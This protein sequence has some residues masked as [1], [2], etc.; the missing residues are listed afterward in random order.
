MINKKKNL[1][2]TKSS[3]KSSGWT[4]GLIEKHLGEPD[5][6]ATNPHYKSGPPV[7]LYLIS[8]VKRCEKKKSFIDYIEK[9][10]SKR[11]I[12]SEK[13]KTRAEEE[14]Q[15][16]FS[17]ISGLDIKIPKMEKGTLIKNAVS[18][19]NELWAERGKDKYAC[20]NSDADFLN[21]ISVNYL[22]HDCS[23]YEEELGEIFGKIGVD[24]GYILLKNK[25]LEKI[26]EIYP[27]LSEACNNQLI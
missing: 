14:R 24:D 1:Y 20:V 16:L 10:K 2:L 19:Y 3:L 9:N 18:H 13:M 25:V 12:L 8:R 15:K 11:A 5:S 7:K 22:R 21:R 26:K 6:T 27:F 23:R 17:Y 4:E